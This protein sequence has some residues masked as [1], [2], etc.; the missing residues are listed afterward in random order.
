[1][2]LVCSTSLVIAGLSI[3]LLY[4]FQ[5]LPEKLLI[6][7]QLFLGSMGKSFIFKYNKIIIQ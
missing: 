1:M 3:I 2:K 4:S 7:K 6:N 5:A